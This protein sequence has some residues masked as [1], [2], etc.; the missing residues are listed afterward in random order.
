MIVNLAAKTG[1]NIKDMYYFNFV[2]AIGWFI[3]F[4]ISFLAFAT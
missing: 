3:N 2:G 1:F 4:K